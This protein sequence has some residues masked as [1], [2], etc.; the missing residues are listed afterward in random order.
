MVNIAV[1]LVPPAAK[2]SFSSIIKSVLR[3]LKIQVFHSSRFIYSELLGSSLKVVLS[4]SLQKK[5]LK[6]FFHMQNKMFSFPA[7]LTEEGLEAVPPHASPFTPSNPK[8]GLTTQEVSCIHLHVTPS[9]Q[10]VNLYNHIHP[11]LAIYTEKVH[12]IP[13]K[14][15]KGKT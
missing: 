10:E 15:P 6:S 9:Q 11:I 4:N 2:T 1:I 12:T 3:A 14:V 7:R 13:K 8:A 5:D